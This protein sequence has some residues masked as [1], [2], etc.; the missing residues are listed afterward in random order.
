MKT[1]LLALILALSMILALCACSAS[2][3]P[4]GESSASESADST[5][6]S[7]TLSTGEES[8]PEAAAGEVSVQ[9]QYP[10]PPAGWEERLKRLEE[11]PVK[12]SFL[13]AVNRFALRTGGELLKGEGGCCSPLSLY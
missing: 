8:S 13:E 7:S 2:A 1:K 4:G 3:A 12:D 5:G 11:N 10:A 9:A 6:E